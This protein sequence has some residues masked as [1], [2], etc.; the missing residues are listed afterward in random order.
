MRIVAAPLVPPVLLWRIV[1][2]LRARG[3][4]LR[5]WVPALPYLL[6]LLA[7][8]TLGEARGMSLGLLTRQGGKSEIRN[9][10]SKTNSRVENQKKKTRTDVHSVRT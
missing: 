10:K 1:A 7:A 8:W 3:Q 2:A 9:P 5:P 4:A 6:P